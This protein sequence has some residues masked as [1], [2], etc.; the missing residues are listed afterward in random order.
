[1]QKDFVNYA[2]III[3]NVTAAILLNVLLVIKATSV[4]KFFIELVNIN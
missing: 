3:H 1:M 2:Q 4:I